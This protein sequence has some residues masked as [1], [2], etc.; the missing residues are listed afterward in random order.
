[1]IQKQKD[2]LGNITKHTYKGYEKTVAVKEKLEALLNMQKTY[3]KM[4]DDKAAW[5]T[6]HKK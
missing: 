1:M 2:I 6:K 4:L 3:Q 5:K